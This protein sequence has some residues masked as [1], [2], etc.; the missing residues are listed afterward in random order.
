MRRASSRLSGLVLRLRAEAVEEAG[1]KRVSRVEAEPAN[2]LHRQLHR[3]L[4]IE[5]EIEE[6]S[7]LLADSPVFRKVSARLPHE[8]DRLNWSPWP[9]R[10]MGTRQLWLRA[11][12]AHRFKPPENDNR[13][14]VCAYRLPRAA[15]VGIFGR[16]TTKYLRTNRPSRPLSGPPQLRHTTGCTR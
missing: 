7:C 10:V 15:L 6:A 4:R 16:S 13:V 1:K 3:K 14:T 9:G 2:W 11:A 5:A 12:G 8:P